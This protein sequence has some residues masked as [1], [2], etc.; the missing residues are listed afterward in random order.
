MRRI[1]A[2]ILILFFTTTALSYPVIGP[3]VTTLASDPEVRQVEFQIRNET[4]YTVDGY[5]YTICLYNQMGEE[6][7]PGGRRAQGYRDISLRPGERQ[8]QKILLTSRDRPIRTTV[9]VLLVAPY[10]GGEVLVR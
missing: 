5:Y 3:R 6:I 10:P 8:Q 2:I 1:L 7:L 4:E 9:D